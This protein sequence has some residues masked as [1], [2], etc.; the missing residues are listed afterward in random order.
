MDW[1]YDLPPGELALGILV[2]MFLANEIGYQI[3]RRSD[4]NE[5][6]RSRSVSAAI[7]ASIIGLVALL[8]GFSY[9]MTSG[10]YNQRLQLVLE[11]ANALGTCYLRA[12]L[13]AEP[14]RGKVRNALREYTKS[15]IDYFERGLDPQVS[16]RTAT[17]MDVSLHAWWS[18]VVDAAKEDRNQIV[19]SQI[20]PAANSV[21]DVSAELAWAMHNRLPPSVLVLLGICMVL[22]AVAIG[23]SS[24]QSGGRHGGLWIA[25]NLLIMLVLFVVMDFDR[26]HHGLIQLDHKPLLE[27]QEEMRE[28]TPA[29]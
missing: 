9:S 10:R 3:G 21:I 6:D 29:P 4:P 12:D 27:L 18:G 14:A 22:S 24:G 23:H 13:L 2:L 5:S 19:P 15:R 26:S 16:R 25:M 1:I 11:E 7:K 8:L 20:V 28:Q 17:G